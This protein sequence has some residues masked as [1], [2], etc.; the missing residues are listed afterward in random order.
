MFGN[1]KDNKVEDL[2]KEQNK[3]AQGT[4]FKGDIDSQGSFRI[5]GKVEGNITTAGKV[6]VGK[7]GYVEGSIQCE[8]ADF[9]GKF[10]GEITVNSTLTLKSSAII[11]G[12]VVT[13]K[14]AIEPGAVFNATCKMKGAVKSLNDE[15]SRQQQTRKKEQTA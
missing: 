8:Y 1:K 14:L 11:E 10:S 12:N 3:I 7:T 9:E 4:T 15:K 6:V 2:T 5:E 13:E